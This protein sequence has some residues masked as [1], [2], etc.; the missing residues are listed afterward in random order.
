MVKGVRDIRQRHMACFLTALEKGVVRK[1]Q[2]KDVELESI[3]RKN[4][5][6]VESM[7]Q[8]TSEAQNWC[9]MAKYNESVVNVLKNNLQQAMQGSNAGKEG[10]GESDADD[11]AS[12][13]DPNNYLSVA[14][15][16][17]SG[18]RDMM[19]KA[20]KAKEVSILL[21]PCRHFCLCKQC[22]GFA[23]VCPVCQIITTASFE[24]YLS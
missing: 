12:C 5:E 14:G 17:S 13:I 2:E 10:R 8:V 9:Y 18:K 19:C 24:V 15:R 11:A 20:C 21:M 16:S 3:T 4:K 7:K 6:L 1:L 23:T 22:E